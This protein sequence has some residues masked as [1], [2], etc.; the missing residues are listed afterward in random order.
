MTFDLK[1][2]VL[3]VAKDRKVELIEQIEQILKSKV[4]PG[5]EAGKLK[6]KLLFG[7]SQFFGK[8]GRAALRSLSERQYGINPGS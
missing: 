6:G 7:A 1:D 2:R 3:R 5:G 8:T 4:L